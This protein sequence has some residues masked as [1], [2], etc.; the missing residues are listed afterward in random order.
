MQEN[1]F[2]PIIYVRGYAMTQ[3]EIEDTVADPYMGFNIGSCKV[4]QLWNGTVKK[5]FFE[6]PL[7]RLLKQFGYDDVYEDGADRVADARA[8][9]PAEAVLPVPYRSIVIY[10]YYEPSSE[11]LGTGEKPDMKRFATGLGQIILDLR[12]RIYPDGAKTVITAEERAMGKLPYDQFRVYLVA[13]SMGGLVCRTFLQNPTY[14]DAKARKL[15]DKV[16]TYATPHNGI[17]VGVLGNVPNWFKL[18]GMNTFNRDE[19]ASLLGLSKPQRD[20]DNVDIITNFDPRR[21]FNLVGTNPGDYKAAAGLSSFAVGD[22]SDGLV[23][24]SNATTRSREGKEF[25]QSPQAFV[26][27]SHSGF[28]GI[29]NSEEGYQNLTRFLFGDVRADGYLDVDELTL[30]PAVQKEKDNGK[31]VRASYLFEVAVSIR[32]KPWQLHRR[33]VNENSAIFRKFDELFPKAS[34]KSERAPDRK[35]SPML[36]NVFLDMGQSQTGKTLAFAADLCV[37]VPE[38]EVDGVLFFKNHFEGGYLFRDMVILEATPP[39]TNKGTWKVEYRFASDPSSVK[40]ASVVPGEDHHMTIEIPVE[41]P[42]PPGIKARLR[43]ET[44]FWNRQE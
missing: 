3:N 36:F 19:I 38:Y 1:A 4:R 21:V 7:V 34:K 40:M 30:P 16:F 13:H 18:Y 15:V 12:D 41:Q 22:A 32:G 9:D 24:I 26:H 23:R 14:G 29:V 44:R 31:E 35:A 39:V 43:V 6:S 8:L 37:R 10:R 5:Y 28:Y 17:E 25:I 27:R 20:G 2:H 11:D 42:K 33:T